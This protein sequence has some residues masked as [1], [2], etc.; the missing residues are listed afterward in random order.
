MYYGYTTYGGAY[1]KAADANRNGKVD[2][3]DYLAILREY[4]GYSKIN[5]Y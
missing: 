1:Y 3:L 5:Q 4:Y 2:K